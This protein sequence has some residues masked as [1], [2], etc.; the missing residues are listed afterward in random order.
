LHDSVVRVL[1]LLLKDKQSV[2]GA[3]VSKPCAG[4]K[5]IL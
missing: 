1:L 3:P 2:A 5:T 4:N